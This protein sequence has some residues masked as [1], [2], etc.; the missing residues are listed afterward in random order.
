MK[1]RKKRK[2]AFEES[3]GNIFA[4]LDIAN[5]EEALAKSQIVWEITKVIKKKKLTQAQVAK[6]LGIGQPKVSLLLRGYLKSFS[7]ERLFRFLNDLGQD[8]YI[9]IKPSSRSRHGST[10]V[11]NSP[12]NFRIAA[13]GK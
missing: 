6:V 8:I 1:R 11:G 13:L 12:S 7:L 10:M 3:S 9:K 4:D 2:I 5:P